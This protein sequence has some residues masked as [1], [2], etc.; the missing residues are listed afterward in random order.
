[1]C[2]ILH[3]HSLIKH[4]GLQLIFPLL[5]RGPDCVSQHCSDVVSGPLLRGSCGDMISG[6]EWQQSRR[7]RKILDA[8]LIIHTSPLD[9]SCCHGIGYKAEI[10]NS[11]PQAIVLA[12]FYFCLHLDFTEW[13]S[14]P[15]AAAIH[16]FSNR[17]IYRLFWQ[18]IKQWDKKYTRHAA[19]FFFFYIIP[20][21]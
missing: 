17:V 5:C 7:L 2:L 4:S 8:N 21:L 14:L 13:K 6:I 15:R 9:H 3:R 20:V 11:S 12:L 16:Y 19:T 10:L 1:M 18:I